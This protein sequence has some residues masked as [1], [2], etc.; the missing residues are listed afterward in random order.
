MENQNMEALLMDYIE[1]NLAAKEQAFVVRKLQENTAW[2]NEYKQLQEVFGLFETTEMLSPDASLKLDFQKM[3]QEEIAIS[4]QQKT[5]R[6]TLKPKWNFINPM[7]VAASV[8]LLLVGLVI[9][10]WISNNQSHEREILALQKEM[11]ATKQLIVLS[12]QNQTSASQRLKGV[13]ASYSFPQMDNEIIDVLINTMNTDENSNV[14]LAAIEALSN[15]AQ[16]TKVRKSLIAS[17]KT[18]VQP[19]VQI[20]LI[21][22]MI[23][24]NEKRAVGNLQQIIENNET[25]D[26]VK[27]EAH[28]GLIKLS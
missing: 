5:V 27:D 11:A 21:N 8:S 2:Q 20:R 23:I 6:R 22:L 16:N 1:G 15:F 19:I 14:R 28:F 9:G 26:I 13:N 4:E 18:Q 10:I 25:T 7:Q 3:L 12:L 24:L 17:L